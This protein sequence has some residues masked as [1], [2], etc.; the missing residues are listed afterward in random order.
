MDAYAFIRKAI[1]EGDYEPG[2]R[3]TEES[4]AAELSLSRTPIRE[5]LQRLVTEGLVTP[6][7]RGI[8]VRTFS[9]K[10][11]KQ[12]YELRALLEGY[13]ASQAALYRME[14]DVANLEQIH[15]QFA[16]AIKR[17]ADK[18]NENI[19]EIARFNNKF[20][21]AVMNAC[22]N[23]HI[24]FMI[25]KVVV[26]PLVFRS[27]YWYDKEEIYRSRDNHQTIIDAIKERNPDRARTAMQEH[28]YKGY[29]HV[30][31]HISSVETGEKEEETG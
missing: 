14:S 7:K 21:E 3:L 19:K 16:E 25:S 12:I 31:R 2:Q 15:E 27:F 26:L 6:L 22:K 4:L 30:L 24:H 11:I 23:D 28:I 8:T 5:A 1:I 10:D 20:H 18:F 17:S 13:A 9:Q 29:D